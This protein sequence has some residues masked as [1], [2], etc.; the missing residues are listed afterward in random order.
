MVIIGWDDH[1]P[2]ERF[3]HQPEGDGAFICL[4]SWGEGFGE[5]GCFYVSYYDTNIGDVNVLYSGITDPDYYTGI[6]QS[7]LCGWIG[8][9]GY[10]QEEAYFANVYQAKAKEELILCHHAQYQL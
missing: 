3:N 5:D 6:Y 10:G 2:K 9:V 8:Q 7:D 1:Y 4:N